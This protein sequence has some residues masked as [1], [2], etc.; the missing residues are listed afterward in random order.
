MNKH[1]NMIRLVI[2]GIVGACSFFFGSILQDENDGDRERMIQNAVL[3]ILDQAHFDPVDLDDE[4]STKAFDQFLEYIDGRKRF[5]THEDIVQ[6]EPYRLDI[7]DQAR[8]G[9][10]QFFDLATE[11]LQK[12]I[13]EAEV[14]YQEILAQPFNFDLKESY[15]F[16]PDKKDYVSDSNELRGRW[17][18]ALKYDVMIKVESKLEKQEQDAEAEK[19]TFAQVE[20]EARQEVKTTFDKWYKTF[21]KVKR[22]DRFEAYLNTFAHLFDPHSDYFNPKEKEDFDISMGGKL[23]GIGARLRTEGDLTQ[24]V[25]IVP[26]GPVWRGKKVDVNDFVLKVKQKGEEPVDVFGMRIDDVVSMIRGKKGTFVTL[27]IKKK[28]GTIKEV[29]IERDVVNIEEAFAKSAILNAPGIIENIGYIH[30]PKFYSS[31]DGPEGNSCAVDVAKEIEKLKENNVN[32]IILDLRNNGG[33]SL[34]DVVNMSGLFIKDGPI[35]QVK[36]RDRK[37]YIY[38][39]EDE[40]VRYSGPL[41]V[42]INSFSAS[43]SEILAAAMQDYDR[44]VIVGSQSFGKGTVQRFISLDRAVRGNSE[45]KPL[46]ELKITMQKF[47]RVDGGSTQ[48]KGV[49]PDISLPDRYSHIEIGERE[50]PFAMEWSEISGLEYDQDILKVLNVDYLNRIS[51]ERIKNNK[52]FGLIEEQ[53]KLYKANRNE[54]EYSLN[55]T[56]Y[57]SL[58]DKREKESEKFDDILDK[59]L[60]GVSVANLPQDAESINLD[61]TTVARNESWLKGIKKDIYI[62]ESLAIIGDL[63]KSPSITKVEN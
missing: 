43:A 56:D 46:G 23:E 18:K 36:P 54:T 6:L 58:L 2:L 34:R 57:K 62:E 30:L 26:G 59:D 41:V 50:Y 38:R 35:V 19:K 3:S 5:F 22:S 7:D 12:R 42:M 61:D 53:A 29:E 1:K 10:L 31:F 33:G 63:I 21:K 4:F 28:D 37:P 44:A 24:V 51:G 14:L 25:D 9:S 15:E 32:G 55:L 27:T 47:Y 13:D 17:R 16:D 49:T 48:L 8:I 40:E 11:L 52:A 60:D 45:F 39:D 20:E